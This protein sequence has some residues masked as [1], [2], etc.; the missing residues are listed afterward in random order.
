MILD[1]RGANLLERP[2]KRWIRSLAAADALL[3]VV[4]DVFAASES[5]SRRN[6]LVGSVHWSEV[7]HLHAYKPEHHGEPAL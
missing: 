5:R 2:P 7:S 6:V 1:S 3:R 4:L